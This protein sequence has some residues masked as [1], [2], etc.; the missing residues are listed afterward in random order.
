MRTKQPKK[1]NR[2]WETDHTSDLIFA[3]FTLALSLEAN[4]QFMERKI[5]T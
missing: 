2:V 5:K 3:L 4:E 1:K